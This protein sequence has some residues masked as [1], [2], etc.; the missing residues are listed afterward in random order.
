M[1]VYDRNVR[2]DNNSLGI[3]PTFK[4]LLQFSGTL[5][6]NDTNMAL[7]QYNWQ[8]KAYR[9]RFQFLHKETYLL[10]NT[11]SMISGKFFIK[12]TLPAS[13]KVGETAGD[14]QKINAGAI[15]LCVIAN[16]YDNVGTVKPWHAGTDVVKCDYDIIF[17]Y[18]DV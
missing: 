17:K 1:I 2:Q 4:E 12:K 15:Y 13:Y 9:G 11:M 10:S 8:N 3:L 14:I 16:D 5:S 18:V 6:I 7:C